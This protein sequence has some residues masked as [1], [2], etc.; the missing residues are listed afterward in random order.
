MDRIVTV[1]VSPHIA[2]IIVVHAHSYHPGVH[3]RCTSHSHIHTCCLRRV[4]EATMS[5]A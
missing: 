4:A 5:E 3:T 2:N 1:R